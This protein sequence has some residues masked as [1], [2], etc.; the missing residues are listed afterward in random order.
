MLCMIFSNLLTANYYFLDLPMEK[1][2]IAFFDFDGTLSRDYI[3]LDFL[4]FL[5]KAK[6]YPPVLYRQQRNMLKANQKGLLSY[7]DW[8]AKWGSVWAEGLAGSQVLKIEKLA[9]ELFKKFKKRIYFSSYELIKVLKKKGYYT[10][11][12]G[13]GAFEVVNL[14]A[15]DLGIDEVQAT[16]ILVK[17]GVYTDKLITNFHQP[18]GKRKFMEGIVKSKKYDLARSVAFGDS[19][20]DLGML[21]KVEFPVALNPSKE[22]LTLAQSKGWPLANYNN[23][24]SEIN[25]LFK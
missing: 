5:L 18:Q 3:S 8:C 9:K 7:G 1:S 25:N 11:L 19:I 14:A 6:A 12:I 22:L 13:A 15:K 4:D 21:E 17:N 23:V 16:K 2:K 10:L 20:H 24:I